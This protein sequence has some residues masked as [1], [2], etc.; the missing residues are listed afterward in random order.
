MPSELG[1]ADRVHEVELIKLVLVWECRKSNG[2]REGFFLEFT[3]CQP[4]IFFEK[5]IKG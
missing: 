1:I 3:G 5:C 2:F 4:G